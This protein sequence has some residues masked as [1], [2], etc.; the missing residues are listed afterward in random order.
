MALNS[1]E[2]KKNDNYV[3][4]VEDRLENRAKSQGR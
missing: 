4:K 2:E 3:S 1:I